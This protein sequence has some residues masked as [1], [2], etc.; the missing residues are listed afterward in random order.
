MENC[1]FALCY[2]YNGSTPLDEPKLCDFNLTVLA[3]DEIARAAREH[4]D[5]MATKELKVK[6]A[7][8]N[9]FISLLVV[10]RLDIQR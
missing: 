2:R 5:V 7:G 9:S 6:C 3:K 10:Q 1:N 8:K 4:M